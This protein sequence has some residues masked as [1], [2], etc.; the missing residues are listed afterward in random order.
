MNEDVV[1]TSMVMEPRVGQ[2]P[3][4]DGT[5]PEDASDAPCVATKCLQKE[6]V[7]LVVSSCESVG[8]TSGH[9]CDKVETGETSDVIDGH[10]D[11]VESAPCRK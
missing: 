2:A 7:C 4:V 9:S 1:D 6:D 8:V 5:Y 10:L 3:F 11:Q